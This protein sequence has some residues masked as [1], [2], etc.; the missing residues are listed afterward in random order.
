VSDRRGRVRV[1]YNSPFAAPTWLPRW[2]AESYLEQDGRRWSKLEELGMVS[3]RQRKAGPPS[4]ES[5]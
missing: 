3:A 5:S 4:I 1:R 2:Q